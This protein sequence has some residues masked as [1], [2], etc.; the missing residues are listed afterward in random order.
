MASLQ[1][2]LR[3]LHFIL[4]CYLQNGRLSYSVVCSVGMWLIFWPH[5]L[6]FLNSFSLKF[7][8]C[9]GDLDDCGSR[10]GLTTSFVPPWKMAAFTPH[11]R[12]LHSQELNEV[13]WIERASTAPGTE[14]ECYEYFFERKTLRMLIS[15][16]IPTHLQ[17]PN[18][19]YAQDRGWLVHWDIC[20]QVQAANIPLRATTKRYDSHVS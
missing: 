14:W 15:S 19:V 17:A 4:L 20:Q 5:R 12:I 2:S 18:I 7:E 16:L 8:R 1:M 3:D 11:F 10:P 6:L 9:S 13:T